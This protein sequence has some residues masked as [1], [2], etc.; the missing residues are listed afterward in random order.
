M[1]TTGLIALIVF[2]LAV[3]A[4]ALLWAGGIADQPPATEDE[5]RAWPGE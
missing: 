2:A 4:A 3:I 5:R 1:T